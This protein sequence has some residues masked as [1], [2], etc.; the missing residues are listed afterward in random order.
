MTNEDKVKNILRSVVYLAVAGPCYVV[1]CL[2]TPTEHGKF[3]MHLNSNSYWLN[4]TNTSII[5]WNLCP[6]FIHLYFVKFTWQMIVQCVKLTVNTSF[7]FHNHWHIIVIIMSYRCL[8]KEG[9]HN[10]DKTRKTNWNII[11][12]KHKQDKRSKT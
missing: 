3:I 6:V 4:R 2:T 11:E 10:L 1:V 9:K 12:V 8:D 7:F 5:V